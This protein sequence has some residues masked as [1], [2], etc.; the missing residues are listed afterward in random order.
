M[1][2]DALEQVPTF[3]KKISHFFQI[4]LCGNLVCIII[5]RRPK[6]RRNSTNVILATLATFDFLLIISSILMLG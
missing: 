3:N 5:L 1:T 6:M 4:G 2:N